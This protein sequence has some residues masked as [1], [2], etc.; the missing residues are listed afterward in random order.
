MV[1]NVLNVFKVGEEI[2]TVAMLPLIKGDAVLHIC[3]PWPKP[4]KINPFC[5]SPPNSI[6]MGSD[7]LV[8]INLALLKKLYEVILAAAY[9]VRS[10]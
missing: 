10:L 6:K 3:D 2:L 4:S 1:L 7:Q 8:Y 9:S 5:N